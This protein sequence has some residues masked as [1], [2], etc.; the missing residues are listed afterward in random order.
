MQV[1]PHTEVRKTREPGGVA[2]EISSSYA[3]GSSPIV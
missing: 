1:I 2:M 3:S